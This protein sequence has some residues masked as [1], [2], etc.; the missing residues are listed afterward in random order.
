MQLPPTRA[1]GL[2]TETKNFLRKQQVP[3]KRFHA[4]AGQLQHAAQILPA[5]RAFFTPINNALKGLPTFVR[6][7]RHGEVRHALLKIATVI[8]NLASRLTHVSKLVQGPLGYIEYCDASPFGA[9]GVWF[10]G[11]KQLKPIV[12]C[13]Q[14]PRDVT[15]NV[16]SDSNPHGTITTSDLE[17]AGVLLQEA[18]LKTA[19][20]STM[21]AK[22]QE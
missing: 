10:G 9:G 22:L 18:V 6:L 8:H 3:L 1:V 4:I 7:S 16:V 19:I 2:L 20:G 15:N 13:I 17:M 12:W 11:R 14:W 21:Q 5:A